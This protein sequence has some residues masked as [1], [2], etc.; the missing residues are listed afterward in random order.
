LRNRLLR[1]SAVPQSDRPEASPRGIWENLEIDHDAD[2]DAGG[3]KKQNKNE[4]RIPEKEKLM[5]ETHCG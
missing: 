1:E 2:Q 5:R 4:Q 3:E